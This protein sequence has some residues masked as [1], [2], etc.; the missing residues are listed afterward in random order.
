MTQSSKFRLLILGGTGEA[1]ALATAAR[2]AFGES[3]RIM[4]SL[5]GRTEHPTVPAGD[6][7]IGGFGGAAALA[8][9]LRAERIDFVIDATHPFAARISSVAREACESAGMPRLVLERPAWRAGPGDKW[10][11]VADTGE[12]A[13]KI[14]ALGR[15]VF[16]TV[17]RRE[18]A[19]FAALKDCW[20]LLRLV[21]PP[22][23]PLPFAD[24]Q[25]ELIVARG[26]FDPRAERE[27]L[28]HYRIDVVVAKAS[29]GQ[30]TE[31]KL[32]AARELG[33]PVILLR[34]PATEPGEHARSIAEAL[35]WLERRIL[36]L[37]AGASVPP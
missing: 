1:A 3:L 25:F 9:Y 36:C 4:T 29:G 27:L 12:A 10:T 23:D 6:I 5:A 37:D 22:K 26:P 15:R 30:A 7:R 16:L 17:G 35:R 2:D 28:E 11:D 21:E 32:V 33:L 18:L 20:F 8:E 34:R 19:P 24:S 13:K 31:G 14:P